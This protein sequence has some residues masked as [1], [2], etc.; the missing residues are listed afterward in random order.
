MLTRILP[1]KCLSLT[2]IRIFAFLTFVI[3]ISCLWIFLVKTITRRRK[4]N[5]SLKLLPRALR[6]LMNF[7]KIPQTPCTLLYILQNSPT[8][9]RISARP[10]QIYTESWIWFL[11][12]FP[13]YRGRSMYSK[14]G[15]NL[16]CPPCTNW[17]LIYTL[18]LTQPPLLSQLL[19]DPSDM[20]MPPVI[21]NVEESARDAC[22][23]G[24]WNAP[25]PPMS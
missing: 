12:H 21:P 14:L 22:F 17:S 3:F 6:S 23:G 4:S 16:S 11:G 8:H 25:S 5:E 10:I 20:Y 24:P 18:K 15:I 1:L 7:R 9:E 13:T 2:E 19:H